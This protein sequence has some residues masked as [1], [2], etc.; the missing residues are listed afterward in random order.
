MGN[1]GKTMLDWDD[2]RYFSALAEHK[3]VRGAAPALGVNPSTVTRRLEQLESN[4][5]VRFFIRT[6]QGLKITREGT[7]VAERVR[8]LADDV[9][10]L[11]VELG[12]L[13]QRLA[14][15]VRC[16]VPDA[17]AADFV[18]TELGAFA[19]RY[20][21][22]EVELVP[23]YQE[24]DLSR[25]EVDIAIRG[26]ETP[27]QDMIG[28]PLGRVALAAY[29]S[30]GFLASQGTAGAPPW[31]EWAARGEVMDLYARLRAQHF[32]TARV[33]L[34]CDQ[35][36]MH[37]AAV[38]ADMGLAILPCFLAEGD[39]RLQRVDDMP[40]LEGPMLWLLTHPDL[41]TAARVQVLMEFL[42]ESFLKHEK[43]MLGLDLM[44]AE[45]T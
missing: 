27:P 33:I 28:R 6:A 43:G 8:A 1:I 41:R 17:L 26:T 10:E 32:P 12:G 37:H 40:V 39:E 11:E 29:G 14:G 16:A 7:L 25:G 38:R 23:G 31:I 44:S 22:I 3:S 20:P 19:A 2:L 45:Q 15:R 5:G 42:R 24:L 4:L 30:H 36:L 13:D 21:D 34:R 18:I 35:I 9:R